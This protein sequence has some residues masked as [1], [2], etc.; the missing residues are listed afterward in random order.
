M[1]PPTYDFVIFGATSFVGQ[2]LTRN[3]IKEYNADNEHNQVN[4]AIAGRNENKLKALRESLGTAAADLPII[5]A[6]ASDG[7]A[8]TQLCNTT[9]AVISTVGP[10]AL[11]GEPLIKA[12][13][14]TGTSYCDLTGEKQWLK[15]MLDRY[16]DTAEQSGAMIVNCCGFDSIPVDFGVYYLQQQARQLFKQP[17]IEVKMRVK[18]IKG[19]ISGGTLAS[20]LNLITEAAG[21][22]ALRRELRDP[23]SLCPPSPQ[24][25]PR[26][27]SVSKPC[28]DQHY[29]SWVAPYLMDSIDTPIVLR[30]NALNQ[31]TGSQHFAYHE[32]V[33]TGS[34]AK[35]LFSA[36]LTTLGLGAF[37]SIASIKPLRNLLKRFLPAPGEGPSP[38]A[39]E[40]GFYKLSFWGKTANG[41]TLQVMVTGDRD[42]GYG[43]TAK[44]LAQAG[45]CLAKDYDQFSRGG[46]F[47]TPSVLFGDLLLER[48]KK[49][50]GLSFDTVTHSGPVSTSKTASTAEPVE[51]LNH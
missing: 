34:G 23:Y 8:L 46:G 2:I 42:P 44:I 29:H 40:K 16:S 22:K 24:K 15:K 12:C 9:R 7:K 21:N 14:D 33:L 39:Q 19:G 36:W 28:F 13:T 3:L 10:Y 5:I 47:W 32:G 6:D 43:S 38:E 37:V 1:T 11:Y 48:L 35:G 45:L 30:S 27:F 49:N 25:R 20:V 4:W 17:C 31:E 26:L 50:S 41:Q 51:S 18:A